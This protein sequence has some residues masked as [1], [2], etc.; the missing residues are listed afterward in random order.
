MKIFAKKSF[1]LIEV[2]LALQ[3]VSLGALYVIQTPLHFFHHEVK[4]LQAMD[5]QRFADLAFSEIKESFYRNQIPWDQIPVKEK[6]SKFSLWKEPI[7]S[8]STILGNVYRYYRIYG[9]NVEGKD[10][11]HYRFLT[12]ELLLSPLALSAKDLFKAALATKKSSKK[13][14][15]K[16]RFIYQLF[17]QK[18]PLIF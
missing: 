16:D 8:S 7:P 3:L 13:E 17:L 6:E 2:L 11:R 1:F 18:N 5:H 14:K 12:V 9:T 4:T 10:H 15:P